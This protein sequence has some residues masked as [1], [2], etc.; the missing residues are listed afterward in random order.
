MFTYQDYVCSAKY[1]KSQIGETPEYAIILRSDLQHFLEK[2]D[3]RIDIPFDII[4]SFPKS[5]DTKKRFFTFGRISGKPVIIQNGYFYCYDGY[6]V[7]FSGFSIRMFKLIG[8]SKLLYTCGVGGINETYKC[9]DIILIT[10]HLNFFGKNPLQG[11]NFS[12]FGERFTDISMA[13]SKRLIDYAIQIDSQLKKGIYAYMPGPTFETPAEI[14][15]LKML[16]ADVV[17]MAL[18]PDV[19]AAVHSGMEIL[20]ISYITSMAAG[21]NNQSPS[22][23]TE[24]SKANQRIVERYINILTNIIT[25]DKIR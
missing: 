25:N 8:I 13:Y 22:S 24:F 18:V 2:L 11:T 7:E 10:D 21:V 19:I 3:D 4:P 23:H 14:R 15:A 20:A 12:E 6:P 16:G 1:L 5:Y 9:G 17:G